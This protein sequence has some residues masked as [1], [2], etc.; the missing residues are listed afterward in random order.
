MQGVRR[1]DPITCQPWR[2]NRQYLAIIIVKYSAQ[3]KTKLYNYCF[4][5]R[6]SH[7]I[8]N[9][10]YL[11]AVIRCSM[12]WGL[13]G[14]N[15]KGDANEHHNGA[16]RVTTKHSNP[17][18]KLAEHLQQYVTQQENKK[19]TK[20]ARSKQGVVWDLQGN[21][22]LLCVYAGVG[23]KCTPSTHIV[24]SKYCRFIVRKRNQ[25]WPQH[26]CLLILVGFQYY[27]TLRKLLSHD[28]LH[29]TEHAISNTY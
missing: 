9:T 26:S 3:H 11:V 12:W 25:A 7:T 15:T 8:N 16:R 14:R 20:N 2:I 24:Y 23:V 28:K 18:V 4:A 17:S 19:S 6:L 22:K 10:R 13:C 27:C 5:P 21:K 29:A 1:M